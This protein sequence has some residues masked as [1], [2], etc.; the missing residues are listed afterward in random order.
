[1]ETR[2]SRGS[3]VTLAKKPRARFIRS[4]ADSGDADAENPRAATRQRRRV[5]VQCGGDDGP[6]RICAIAD[7]QRSD[8]D[9]PTTPRTVI[10]AGESESVPVAADSVVHKRG[11]R[12]VISFP[13]DASFSLS[14]DPVSSLSLSLAL[15]FSPLRAAYSH[16]QAKAC[17]LLSTY[18][19]RCA[20]VLSVLRVYI[21]AAGPRYDPTHQATQRSPSDFA[22]LATPP[23]SRH[24]H[25][26]P[27]F[28]LPYARKTRRPPDT[29]PYPTQSRPFRA[30]NN[31]LYITSVE[32]SVGFSDE[33]SMR[34]LR[35]FEA[36]EAIPLVSKISPDVTDE[37]EK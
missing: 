3:R 21:K 37:M 5:D 2:L 1:M 31:K 29:T 30:R 6:V 24:S 19:V 4:A 10:D 32:S 9:E 16:R 22:L 11:G 12:S 35:L 36:A 26:P 27:L 33:S 15:S 8:G 13:L 14:S 34:S 28:F 23:P 17:T 25:T 20:G 18:S 7:A